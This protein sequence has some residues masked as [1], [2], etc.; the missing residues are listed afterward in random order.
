M[1]MPIILTKNKPLCDSEGKVFRPLSVADIKAAKERQRARKQ[2]SPTSVQKWLDCE[3]KWVFEQTYVGGQSP[4]AEL[5]SNIHEAIYKSFNLAEGGLVQKLTEKNLSLP[6]RL[7]KHTPV[8]YAAAEKTFTGKWRDIELKGVVDLYINYKV[9]DKNLNLIV[10]IDI[11]TMKEVLDY[12]VR[13]YRDGMQFAWYAYLTNAARVW[14]LPVPAL[15]EYQ[16]NGTAAWNKGKEYVNANPELC[17]LPVVDAKQLFEER[18]A[19]NVAKMDDWIRGSY[20]PEKKKAYCNWC[21][22]Y[23]TG[24][25][26]GV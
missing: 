20:L 26:A 17:S 21:S 16:E 1:K 7:M 6:M 25:C 14:C 2:Y 12:K 19:D 3:Y 22:A 8:A 5:G 4:E 13:R 9:Q 15:P 10:V 23:K 11:K 24:I 18:C